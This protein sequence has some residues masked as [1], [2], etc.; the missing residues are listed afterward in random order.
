MNNF[1]NS[2]IHISLPKVL[3]YKMSILHPLIENEEIVAETYLGE[4]DNGNEQVFR[5]RRTITNKYRMIFFRGSDS[6]IQHSR[7]FDMEFN[8]K[9][10]LRNFFK[11]LQEQIV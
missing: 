1:L 2:K 11:I 10:D 8:T 5:V 7:L 4:D 9:E 6:R 3:G